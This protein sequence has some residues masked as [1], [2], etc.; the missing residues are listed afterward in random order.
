MASMSDLANLLMA[1]HETITSVESLTGGLFAAELTAVPGVS[2][3]L[4]GAV[5]TYAASA[6]I[7][8][9]GV[10]QADVAQHGVVSAVVAA[11]MAVGGRQTL[12]TD[13][14]VSFTGVAGPDELEGHPA[15]TVFIGVASPKG[16]TTKQFQFTGDRAAVRQ[17]SVQVGIDAVIDELRRLDQA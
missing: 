16:V 4:P 15:G 7:S 2:S 8:L 5:V 17:A 9:V 13:W 11:D 6:K 3:I 14:A 12:Q 1:R 10:P